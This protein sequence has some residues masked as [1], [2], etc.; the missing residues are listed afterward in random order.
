MFMSSS[1]SVAIHLGPAH[2]QNLEVYKNPHFEKFRVYS[3]SHRNWHWNILKGFWMC[4]RLKAHL[5]HGQ[6]RHCDPM[7]KQKYVYT[8]IPY[9]VCGRCMI[10]EIQF[11]VRKVKGKKSK[12]PLLLIIAGNR[13]GSYGIQVEYF[14]RIYVIADFLRDPDWF[15]KAEHCTDWIIFMSMIN[16]ID[17]TRKGNDGICISNSEK[18]NEYAKR[19]SQEQWTFL[20]PGDEKKWYGTLPE[21]PEG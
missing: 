1:M 9:N 8:Q 20:G 2:L 4:I 12:C 21:T 3:I 11:L 17:W 5:H 13:W 14:P 7:D 19:F 15:A 10:T 16:D 6:D 18:V